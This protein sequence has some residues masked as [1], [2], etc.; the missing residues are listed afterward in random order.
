MVCL[1][2]SDDRGSHT[3]QAA[4]TTEPSAAVNLEYLSTALRVRRLEGHEPFFSLDP[5]DP[6]QKHSMQRKR[7]IPQ[8]LESTNAG[9]VLFQADYYLKELSMGEYEQPVVG[10]RSCFDYS[11]SEGHRD[12][13]S[14][15]EWFM[16]RKAEINM[17]KS[18]VLVP[19]VKLG[20]E[21]REQQLTENAMEDVPITRSDHPMV[22][23]AEAFSKN[24][25]LIAERRSVIYHL[26]EL[27]KATVLAKFVQEHQL[28]LTESWFRLNDRSASVQRSLEVPQLWNQRTYTQIQVQDGK[29]VYDRQKGKTVHSSAHGVYGGVSLA[30][31]KLEVVRKI[32]KAPAPP[33]EAPGIIS[34]NFHVELESVARGP[35]SDLLA[36]ARRTP[37]RLAPALRP[38]AAVPAGKET[39]AVV[40]QGVDL[41]LDNF[42]VS[43]PSDP[44]SMVDDPIP[45]S[46]CHGLEACLSVGQAFWR[47]VDGEKLRKEEDIFTKESKAFFRDLFNPSLTDRRTDGDCFA[48]PA[49]R[50]KYI[51]KLHDLL[52]EESI[53]REKRLSHFLSKSFDVCSPGLLFPSSWTPK[54]EVV[55]GESAAV[56]TP[57]GRLQGSLQ[58]VPEREAAERVLQQVAPIFDRSTEDGIRFRVYQL[59]SLEVRTTQ[60]H[61]EKETVGIV[62]STRAPFRVDPW[63]PWDECVREQEHVVKATLYVE[64]SFD[65]V[66]DSEDSQ[67]YHYYVVLETECGHKVV[68]EK[69]RNGQ[70]TW[71]ENPE[72]LDDRNSLAKVITSALGAK[73]ST[74]RELRKYQVSCSLPG[75][76]CVQSAC[77]EYAKGACCLTRGTLVAQNK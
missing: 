63:D 35:R 33:R 74:V 7:F 52:R 40:P 53:M 21:A 58:E 38:A 42:D 9:E 39:A 62:F 69:R 14:A 5:V 55:S 34:R 43:L 46:D 41:C 64:R 66:Y 36:M 23:Y 17:S 26:R 6:S 59:G 15:R 4:S 61:N 22:K 72:D 30:L 54:T 56:R 31:P 11:E 65:E 73:G 76:G 24:F 19:Y 68:T 71:F 50:A 16:V 32:P 70:T 25:D 51:A 47:M 60:K 67:F 49:S 2:L 37:L 29:I 44:T 57:E 13:W 10:M 27:A 1:V 3:L 20:V 48:P 18:N 28:T 8:W 45:F 12:A 75:H 77:E